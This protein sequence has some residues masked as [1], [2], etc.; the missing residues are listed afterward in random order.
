M[1]DAHFRDT[2]YFMVFWIRS[3]FVVDHYRLFD[4]L[5]PLAFEPQIADTSDVFIASAPVVLEE[6][7]KS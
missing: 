2:F 1:T 7:R 4:E 5:H 6:E 3:S